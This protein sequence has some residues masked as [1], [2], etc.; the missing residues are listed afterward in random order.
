MKEVSA[1][2]KRRPGNN[3]GKLEIG[4]SLVYHEDVT[5]GHAVDILTAQES[6]FF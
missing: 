6:P 4:I 1:Q 5:G 2:R 3:V